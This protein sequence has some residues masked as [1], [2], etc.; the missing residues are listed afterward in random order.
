M[1]AQKLQDILKAVARGEISSENAFELLKTSTYDELE[2]AKIDSFRG[3]RQG[4]PEVIFGPGKT[5]PQIIKIAEGLLVHNRIVVATKISAEVADQVLSL[6]PEGRYEATSKML[7]FGEFPPADKTKIVSVVTAGTADVPIAEEAALY[8]VA[9]GITVNRVF[10]VGVAGI[11]RLFP[12]LETLNKSQA[13][14]VVAGMDGALASVIGGLIAAPIIAVPTSV[15]YGASFQGISA[16]LAMLSS[17]A[18]GLT[19]VNI[20][21]GFGAAVG[22]LRVLASNTAQQAAEQSE[23]SR[24]TSS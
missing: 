7:I 5:A 24:Q 23:G 20:D 8:L 1:D 21:N 14:I 6:L 4:I 19:V 22:A 11:H 10:D 16:L 9:S 13:V 15:G 17:C 2:F 18:A 12:H 3:I